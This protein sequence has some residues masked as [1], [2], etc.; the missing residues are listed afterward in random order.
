[1]FYAGQVPWHGQGTAV[2]SEVTSGAALKLGGI[3]WEVERQPIFLASPIDESIRGLQVANNFAIVRKDNG[4]ALGVVGNRFKEIQ[5]SQ[6]FEFMDALVGERL[7]IYHTA[8]A[9]GQG[10]KVWL[11]AKIPTPIELPG[12]DRVDPYML[13]VNFHDGSGSFKI[14]NTPIRVV[15]QNTLNAALRGASQ[16]FFVRHTG[17]FR[18]RL[19]AAKTHFASVTRYFEVFRETMTRLAAERFTDQQMKDML[20]VICPVTPAM[21]GKTLTMRQGYRDAITT[22]FAG[23]E[24]GF[25]E[26]ECV[27]GT[28][29]GAF[30]AFAEY[31][32]WHRPTRGD[33]ESYLNSVWMGSRQTNTTHALELLTA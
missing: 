25:S 9:L 16:T 30:N 32:T 7:A 18:S 26:F 14:L 15:C 27:R 28:K 5:N 19:D 1:M 3:D 4:V 2:E 20:D 11:L 33:N 8:G 29:W 21:E 12:G 17:N 13:L 24:K 6:A 10:E 23:A 31:E 22:L